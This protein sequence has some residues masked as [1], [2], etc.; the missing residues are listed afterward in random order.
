MTQAT[1]STSGYL[2]STDWNTFN[3]KAP[4][5]TYTTNY[6]PFGQ[7]TTTPNLSSSFTY[8]TGTGSLTA[9]QIVASNG[10]VVNNQTIGTTF[11]IPSG[12]SATSAGPITIS[13]GVSVTVPTG[14]KW[15][16]L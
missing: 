14:G 1:T 13:S 8:V 5:V 6:V 16:V 9:P 3:G 15:V 7:C 12:Y 4:S 2:S 10:I 11:S